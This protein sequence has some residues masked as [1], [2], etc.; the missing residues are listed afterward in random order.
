MLSSITA[1]QSSQTN[2]S[3]L[4]FSFSLPHSGHD[5]ISILIKEANS[6]LKCF[7][8]VKKMFFKKCFCHDFE[9][10]NEKEKFKK[11]QEK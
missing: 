11:I 10:K 3:L 5:F 4:Y 7:V 8:V 2:P 1:P 9:V 6:A